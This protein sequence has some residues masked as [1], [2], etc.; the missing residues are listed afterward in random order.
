MQT[1]F[2]VPFPIPSNNTACKS[3]LKKLKLQGAFKT[4]TNNKTTHNFPPPPK[5]KKKPPTPPPL[6]FHALLDY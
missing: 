3:L 2:F 5:K 4:K 1:H 6:F